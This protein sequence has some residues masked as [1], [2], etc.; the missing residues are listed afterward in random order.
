MSDSTHLHPQDGPP[1]EPTPTVE[2]MILAAGNFI[3][4][5]P[6]L[7][8]DVV[9]EATAVVACHRAWRHGAILAVCLLCLTV[10]LALVVPA[11]LSGD[12]AEPR[13]LTKLGGSVS[14]LH[15]TGADLH[16]TA[17]S[18]DRADSAWGLVKLFQQ[19]QAERTRAFRGERTR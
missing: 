12:P 4:V 17:P 9:E 18:I 14:V 10:P 13:D 11:A 8:P 19:L 7:R 15:A 16:R 1:P 5:D 6:F 2:E 3:E